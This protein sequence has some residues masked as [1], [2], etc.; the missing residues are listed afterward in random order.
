MSRIRFPFVLPRADHFARPPVDTVSGRASTLWL[1]L[2]TVRC[3]RPAWGGS[4]GSSALTPVSVFDGGLAAWRA[5]G[6]PL[7]PGTVTARAPG[8]PS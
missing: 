2:R 6:L 7:E 5:A 1:T 3:G 4:C 8:P